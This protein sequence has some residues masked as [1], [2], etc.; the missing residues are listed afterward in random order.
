MLVCKMIEVYTVQTELLG[1][2]TK[3]VHNRLLRTEE[4]ANFA[5]KET[6]F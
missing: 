1:R 6:F 3:I 5:E 4:L 2:E